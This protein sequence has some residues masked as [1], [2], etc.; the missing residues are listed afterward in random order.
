[1]THNG[2][3]LLDCIDSNNVFLS[4][5]A[6]PSLGVITWPQRDHLVHIPRRRDRNDRLL[7]ILARRSVADFHKFTTVLSKYHVHLVPQLVRDGGE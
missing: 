4:E 5:L 3:Q 1:M 7:E 2:I 6:R